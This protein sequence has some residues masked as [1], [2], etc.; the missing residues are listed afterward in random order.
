M[1]RDGFSQPKSFHRYSVRKRGR[2]FSGKVKVK[3]S[4]MPQNGTI[5]MV[6]QLLNAV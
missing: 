6:Q 4:N 2:R 1:E 3:I 5:V